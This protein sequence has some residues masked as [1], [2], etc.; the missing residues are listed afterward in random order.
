MR[1]AGLTLLYEE[2]DLAAA[3]VQS[4]ENLA[5]FNWN[6]GMQEWHMIGGEV[7]LVNNKVAVNLNHLSTFAL[8]EVERSRVPEVY[9]SYNPFSPNG[10]GIADTTTLSI[11]IR[12]QESGIRG[13]VRVEIFDYI[14]KLI[15]TLVH[16]E[17]LSGHV[18]IVWDGED[19]N[20]DP[21]SIGPYIYQ[22]SIGK[23]IRNG[24]LIVA[25]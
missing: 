20:G 24:V 11:G 19:E 14:G 3:G 5:I 25:R 18:S 21:V 17:A 9:W 2:T 10:D 6:E 1:P 22:V 13:Q 23:E 4:E 12:D 15:R 8:F 7:D 16:E